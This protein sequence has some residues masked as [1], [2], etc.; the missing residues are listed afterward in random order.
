MQM[1]GYDEAAERIGLATTR[2]QRR[3]FWLAFLFGIALGASL[4]W[5]AKPATDERASQR[6]AQ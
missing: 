3:L 4:G 5:L 2:R 6:S 1:S